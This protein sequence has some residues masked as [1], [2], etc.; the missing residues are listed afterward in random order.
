MPSVPAEHLVLRTAHEVLGIAPDASEAEI[1]AAYREKVRM[2]HPDK[3]SGL[4]PEYTEIAERGMKEIN[5]TY[6]KLKP[7]KRN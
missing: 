1:V 7:K 2:Y 4:A 5:T 6:A 3:M